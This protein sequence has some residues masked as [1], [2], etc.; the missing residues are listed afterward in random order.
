MLLIYKFAYVNSI[1]NN[2]QHYLFLSH[3]ETLLPTPFWTSVLRSRVLSFYF[4]GCLDVFPYSKPQANI[5]LKDMLGIVSMWRQIR[6]YPSNGATTHTNAKTSRKNKL[7][8]NYRLEQFNLLFGKKRR[9]IY[10]TLIKAEYNNRLWFRLWHGEWL[11]A[12]LFVEKMMKLS[13]KHSNFNPTLLAQNQTNGYT[14]IG[15]A[16][17]IGKAKKLTK[18]FTLGVPLFFTRYIYYEKLPQGFSKRLVLRDDVNKSL[19]KKVRRRNNK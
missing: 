6:G 1:K 2:F 7:L 5:I 10:P 16:A 17:K 3:K 19:G 14:R 11:Q 8:F 13:H 18:V 9:N 4:M 12:S 15:K